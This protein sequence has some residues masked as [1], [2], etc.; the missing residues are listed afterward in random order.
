MC[1]NRKEIGDVKYFMSQMENITCHQM[2]FVRFAL[3]KLMMK[4]LNNDN[5]EHLDY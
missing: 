1:E 2:Y 5:N 3:N 4:T